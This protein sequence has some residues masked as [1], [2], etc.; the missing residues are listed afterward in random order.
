MNNTSINL[1]L[2]CNKSMSASYHFP[3]GLSINSSPT[4]NHN[5]N[6]N[7]NYNNEV[8]MYNDSSNN[9]NFIKKIQNLE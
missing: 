4:H 5:N 3:H 7:N 1:R 9:G 2:G 8:I 6:N